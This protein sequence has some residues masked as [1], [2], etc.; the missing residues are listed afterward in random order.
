MKKLRVALIG[1]G[2]MHANS[3]HL[4]QLHR[5]G[6][7]SLDALCDLDDRR[8]HTAMEKY[9]VKRGYTN[10]QKMIEEVDLEAV[11]V[12]IRPSRLKDV[13]IPCFERGLAVSVEKSP[14]INPAETAAMLEAAEKNDCC[15]MVGFNR[16]F[17]PVVQK[18]MDMVQK[19]NGLRIT[20]RFY[21]TY[22]SPLEREHAGIHGLDMMR[23]LGGD[24]RGVTA[25]AHRRPGGD[26]DSLSATLEFENGSQGTYQEIHYCGITLECYEVH[27]DGISLSIDHQK[28]TLSVSRTKGEEETMSDR[29]IIG[30][31][32]PFEWGSSFR[33]TRY[34]VDWV[35]ARKRPFP[36]LKDSL[37]TMK[38][39]ESLFDLLEG[40]RS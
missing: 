3:S 38:L 35:L 24:V 20:G 40:S 30:G 37:K 31:S 28:G 8:L 12:I 23:C 7:V 39:N 15:N 21:R 13:V 26:T 6:Q 22:A 9:G 32:D 11:F 18:A 19:E 4:P 17:S 27:A 14:G 2:A 29:D 1:C 34:F 36:D 10:F 33:E 25:K 16:R 5:L